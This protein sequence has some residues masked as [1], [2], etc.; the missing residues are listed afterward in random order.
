M[1]LCFSVPCRGQGYSGKIAVVQIQDASER[2][3]NG[4][5]AIFG[6][7]Y[8]GSIP[9]LSIHLLRTVLARRTNLVQAPAKQDRSLV[10]KRTTLNRLMEVRFLSV[11]YVIFL[12]LSPTYAAN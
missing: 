3:T 11:L 1:A 5:S 6:V 7:A 2:W 8:G 9:P 4:K 12:R 10:V